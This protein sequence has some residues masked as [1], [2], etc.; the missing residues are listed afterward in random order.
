M[1][2]RKWKKNLKEYDIGAANQYSD[3]YKMIPFSESKQV[4]K[5]RVEGEQKQ[6]AKNDKRWADVPEKAAD[7]NEDV[8]LNEDKS[9]N[10]EEEVKVG[11]SLRSLSF[12]EKMKSLS[13]HGRS[14]KDRM[15]DKTVSYVEMKFESSRGLATRK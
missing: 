11:K 1:K 13:P 12:C 5:W 6:Y 3:D 9:I 10:M 14:L 7:V 4:W 2:G 15:R 8:D